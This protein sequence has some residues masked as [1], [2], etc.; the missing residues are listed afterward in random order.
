MVND[1]NE[2]R[3]KKTSRNIFFTV[4][5]QILKFILVFIGRIIFVRVL[6]ASY[7]GVNGLFSN[8]LT[9]LSLADLGM[10][11]AMMYNLYKPIAEDDKEKIQLFIDYFRR[12]YNVIAVVVLLIGLAFIPFLKYIVNLPLDMPNIYLYYIL[13]LLNSVL[14]YLFVYKTTLLSADQKMYIINKYDMIFQVILFILQIGVLLFTKSFALY[15]ISNILCTFLGNVFKVKAADRIYPFLKNKTDKQL[16]KEDRKNVFKNIESLF[17]YKIGSIIQSNTD[18]I[19]IS[20]FVGTIVVGYYSNYS[21]L[22]AQG[23]S[24]LTL[25]FTSLKASVGN[26][27][28]EKEKKDKYKMF[29]ILEVYNY[30]LVGAFSVLLLILLPDFIK[31][32]FGDQYVLSEFSLI[33][34]VLNFYTS[35]IRQTLW[36][37]RETSG[38]F[39]KTKYITIVTSILNILLSLVLGYYYGLVGIIGATVLSRMIYAWWKEPLVIFKEVFDESARSYYSKYF[40]RMVLTCVIYF[41]VKVITGIINID[42]IIFRLL[43]NGMISVFTLFIVCVIIYRKDPAYKFLL[44]KFRIILSK[45]KHKK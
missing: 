17:F 13:L 21:T 38:T 10:T 37:F 7:L 29:N 40:L 32:S 43:V 11:T 3:F 31:L 27:L 5:S 4:V 44:D 33:V 28:V 36:V 15:L 14:S 41:I 24:F 16:S 18:N 22:I 23:A 39:E 2:T 19:L 25:V 34:I 35:N 20:I 26:Y 6:G 45:L 9:I 1:M 12:I 8:V 30:W 42:D